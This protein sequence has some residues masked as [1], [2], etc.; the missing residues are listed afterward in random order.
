MLNLPQGFDELLDE[1]QVWSQPPE[2]EEQQQGYQNDNYQVLQIKFPAIKSRL[3]TPEDQLQ[4][5]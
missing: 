4:S 1:S 3:V 2:Q 5:D